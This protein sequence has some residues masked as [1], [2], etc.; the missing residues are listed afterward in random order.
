MQS[1]DVPEIKFPKGH[2]SD[3]AGRPSDPPT[4]RRSGPRA[5]RLALRP[6]QVPPPPPLLGHFWRYELSHNFCH[7]QFETGITRV[8]FIFLGTFFDATSLRLKKSCKRRA[9]SFGDLK[10]IENIRLQSTL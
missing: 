6:V 3:P 2:P 4:L 5:L 7:F 10:Y 1:R 8:A 9:A